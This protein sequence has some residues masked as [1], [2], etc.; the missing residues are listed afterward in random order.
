MAIDTIYNNIPWMSWN[1]FLALIPLFLACLLFSGDRKKAFI[2]GLAVIV[3]FIPRSVAATGALSNILTSLDVVHM[4]ALLIV[5]ALILYGCIFS[6]Y[7]GRIRQVSGL[8]LFY[9]FLPNAPYVL[10]DI[11]HL[12]DHIRHVDAEIYTTTVVVPMYAVFMLIGLTAYIMSL[13]EFERWIIGIGYKRYAVAIEVI[14][15]LLCAIGIYL[16]RFLRLNSW[17]IATDPANVLY[18]TFFETASIGTFKIVLVTFAIISSLYYI[19]KWLTNI[20]V[21][22]YKIK[23][24]LYGRLLS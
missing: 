16:G 8:F 22:H 14:T 15:H 7:S 12:F 4:S 2:T 11:I 6:V 24:G 23:N 10:T 21:E 18:S 17:E 5:T 3:A 9:L 13:V 1:L 19:G 20:I